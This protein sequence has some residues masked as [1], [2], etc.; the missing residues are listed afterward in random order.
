MDLSTQV[1]GSVLSYAGRLTGQLMTVSGGLLQAAY[2]HGSAALGG[3]VPGRNTLRD[4]PLPGLLEI[5]CLGLED[6]CVRFREGVVRNGS[7]MD[8][9]IRHQH[10]ELTVG[11]GRVGLGEPFIQLRKVDTPV[12]SGNPQPLGNRLPIRISRP[13]RARGNQRGR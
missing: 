5:G 2:L 6:K 3:W 10:L 12:A 13:G 9:Q 4:S 7:G 8:R 11:L 1:P